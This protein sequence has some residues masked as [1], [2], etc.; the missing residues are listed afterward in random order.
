MIEVC[1]PGGRDVFEVEDPCMWETSCVRALRHLRGAA[2][3]PGSCFFYSS[4]DINLQL[5]SA[6]AAL[7]RDVWVI[8]LSHCMALALFGLAQRNKETRPGDHP[9]AY[10]LPIK[11]FVSRCEPTGLSLAQ[12]QDHARGGRS[13]PVQK[14]LRRAGREPNRL[15]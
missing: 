10:L 15:T 4:F 14:R 6:R 5:S 13:A 3:N 2:V 1:G 8:A 12:M 7:D 9:A 11:K